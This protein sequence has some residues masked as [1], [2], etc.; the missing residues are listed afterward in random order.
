MTTGLSFKSQVFKLGTDAL[1]GEKKHPHHGIMACSILRQD[2][3]IMSKN[4]FIAK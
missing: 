2:K 3:D 1:R 4:I